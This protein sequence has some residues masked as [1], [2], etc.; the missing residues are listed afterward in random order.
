MTFA[1]RTILNIVRKEQ[2]AGGDRLLS[3]VLWD[4]FTGSALYGDILNRSMRPSFMGGVLSTMMSRS[5][6]ANGKAGT[7]HETV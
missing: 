3:G 6:G 7:S 1:R 5:H 4:V 2:A